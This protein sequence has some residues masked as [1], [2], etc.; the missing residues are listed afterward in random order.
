MAY[1]PRP[2]GREDAADQRQDDRGWLWLFDSR[3]A[4]GKVE[5]G[6][7]Q[8]GKEQRRRIGNT[9]PDAV[10]N[11]PQAHGERQIVRIESRR[12]CTTRNRRKARGEESASG[13]RP[14]RTSKRTTVQRALK[15]QVKSG[16]WP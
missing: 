3:T 6:I 5:R 1:A 2:K 8:E 9:K 7:S 14:D 16:T 10:V 11:V 4:I 13:W 12:Q 15:E